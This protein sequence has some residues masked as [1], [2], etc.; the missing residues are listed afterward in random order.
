MRM[1]QQE[2]EEEEM[3]YEERLWIK[4]FGMMPMTDFGISCTEHLVSVI[5][6]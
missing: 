4:R 2:L 6:E 1:P 3:C 5:G